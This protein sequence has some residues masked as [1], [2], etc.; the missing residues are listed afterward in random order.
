MSTSTSPSA[1][2]R[3]AFIARLLDGFGP[4]GTLEPEAR[5]L[6]EQNVR[7]ATISAG[8][9]LFRDGDACESFTLV[10]EGRVRVQKVSETGRQIVLYRVEPGQTCVLTTNALL[11]ALPYGAEGVT[12]TDVAA[13]VLSVGPFQALLATSAV[14]RRFVFS[15]YATRIGDLLMLID[16][17]AFGRIDMR[18]AQLLLTRADASGIVVATHQDLAIELGSAREVISRQ[19]KDFERRGWVTAARGH[20]MVEDR[21]ALDGL[22]RR[23]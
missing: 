15:A 5:R 18:L 22:R 14:F 21:A 16:E 1:V 23:G 9:V 2:S 8:S 20:V 17:V 11:A 13:A 3:P 4:L 12:E 19:I 10:L 7:P 6:L